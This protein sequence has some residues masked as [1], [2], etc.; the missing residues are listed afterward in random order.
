[1]E[2]V[3]GKELAAAASSLQ[4]QVQ[5][6]CEWEESKTAGVEEGGWKRK[7]CTSLHRAGTTY[8]VPASTRGGA[9]GPSVHVHD[10]DRRMMF[11]TSTKVLL[12]ALDCSSIGCSPT[13]INLVELSGGVRASLQLSPLQRDKT[14]VGMVLEP[15][16]SLLM[17][18]PIAR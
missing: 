5:V 17:L 11:G 10:D 8:R 14:P 6:E 9:C 4:W 12:P 13:L 2:C 1:M 18:M 7:S 16:T 3:W 15:R